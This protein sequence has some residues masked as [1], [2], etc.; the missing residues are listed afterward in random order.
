MNYKITE[1]YYFYFII[2]AIGI[3]IRLYYS[4]F[5]SYW[6]DEQ[7]AFFV[8]DPTLNLKETI[9]RS[10]NSDYSPLLYNFF[11]KVFF[12]IFGY[13][14]D[15]GRYFSILVGFL[16]I[17]LLAYISFSISKKRSVFIAIFLSSMNIY[18]ISYSAE[19]R[20]Y[21]TIFLLSLVNIYLFFCVFIFKNKNKFFEIAFPFSVFLILLSHPFTSLIIIS[22]IIFIFIQDLK[23][24]KINYKY[25]TITFVTILLYAIIEHDYL[26]LLFSYNPPDFFVKN[27]DLVFFTNFY[28][29]RFFGSKIMGYIFLFLLIF[30]LVKNKQ[31]ILNN[32][33]YQ[34]LL[35]LLITIY[36]I[37]ILYGLIINPV[38]KDKY[39][40]FVLIPVILLISCLIFEI[41]NL[42]LRRLLIGLILISTIT[43]QFFE[44]YNKKL[45]KPDFKSI[46]KK[47]NE[48]EV[49]N[50][51]VITLDVNHE[52]MMD[53]EKK[54]PYRERDIIKNYIK[55]F[56]N[57]DK[58]FVF[59]NQ[60]KIPTEF[61]SIWLICYEPIVDGKCEKNIRVNKNYKI[62]K[63]ISSYQLTSYLLKK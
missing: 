63:E 16:S 14:P 55:N 26:K 20:A 53:I 9:I 27:P 12:S 49:K 30:L 25:Y 8:S 61:N 48:Q 4:N 1:N 28:F 10:L 58:N 57:I 35:I 43:N 60:E 29:D 17:I 2:L 59:L 18:L 39:I 23:K 36:L 24:R 42:R 56:D 50:I 5:E 40:I 46:F 32:K 13:S 15:V 52:Y 33:F 6:I 41:R 47:L 44:I 62:K 11:L 22:E 38:L 3:I 34:F 45:S 7:I 54:D 21:S 37:P 51:A 19:T 31:K